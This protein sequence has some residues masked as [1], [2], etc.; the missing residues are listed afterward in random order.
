M[1][2]YSSA[3]LATWITLGTLT[4]QS[5]WSWLSVSLLQMFPSLISIALTWFVPDS[6]RWLIAQGKNEQAYKILL[7]NH[8]GG[9]DSDP[10][11]SFEYREIQSA[12]AFVRENGHG[13]WLTLFRDR[14]NQWRT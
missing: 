4:I 1:L 2:Y 10:L 9:D 3:T 6:P 12:L 7:K 13:T 14:G 5:D 8:C 11:A